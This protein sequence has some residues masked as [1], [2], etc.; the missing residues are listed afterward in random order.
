LELDTAPGRREIAVETNFGI[1]PIGVNI[2][3][4]K[5]YAK[6][7]LVNLIAGVFKKHVHAS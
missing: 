7:G 4:R 6:T 2:F 5:P 3:T 1:V